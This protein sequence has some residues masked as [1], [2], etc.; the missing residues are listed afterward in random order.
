MDENQEDPGREKRLAF[1]RKLHGQLSGGRTER[2]DPILN[3]NARQR[4]VVAYHGVEAELDAGEA[5]V[6][7]C[8]L[9]GI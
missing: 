9:R 7:A 2:T 5:Y 3:G 6:R 4:G 1:L 8:E